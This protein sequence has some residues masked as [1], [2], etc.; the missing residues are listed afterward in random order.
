MT[1]ELSIIV[2]AYQAGQTLGKCIVS[3]LSQ[4]FCNF[5]LIVV[6]D[7]STDNSAG[8]ALE[9]ASKDSRIKVINRK[10]GGLSAARNT[11]ID[12]ATTPWITFVDSDDTIAEGTL[13][14]N[15]EWLLSHP[16]TDLLEYPVSVHHGGPRETM[17]NF[18]DE[19]V[20]EC[21]MLP[22]WIARQEYRHCYAWNKIYRTSL[23]CQVRFPEG[24]NFED[25]A[26]MPSIIEQCNSIRYSSKGLYYYNDT[27][28]G[29]TRHYTFHNQEPL[30]RHNM[31]LFIRTFTEF[32]HT[33]AAVLKLVASNLLT[34]LCGCDGTDWNYIHEAAA[35]LDSCQ[36]SGKD[37]MR[38]GMPARDKLKSFLYRALGTE[39]ACRLFARKLS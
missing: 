7:G 8:I 33:D 23:F 28:S 5:E 32:S 17:L 25:A 9:F 13:K 18:T 20:C 34:D 27:K 38:S 15:M 24:E 11:G 3:I 26:I 12:A 37:I 21:P 1:P 31:S 14:E 22:H 2:P 10:N 36:V 4:S 6:N 29:I 19:T 35:K 39:R 30:F 16:E